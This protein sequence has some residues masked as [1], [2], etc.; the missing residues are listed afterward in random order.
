MH[1]V[2]SIFSQVLKLFSRGGFRE[3]RSRSTRP[4]GSAGSRV[5]ANSCLLFCSWD[6]RIRL[7]EFAGG[8]ACL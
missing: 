3:R 6:G 2:C 7:R 8:L 1:K 5:W 4:S